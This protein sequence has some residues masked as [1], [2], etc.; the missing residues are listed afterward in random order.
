MLHLGVF[1]HAFRAEHLPVIFAVELDLLLGMDL[2]VT[3][4]RK[5]CDLFGSVL[6]V[7][8]LIGDAHLKSRQHLVV[9]RQALGRLVMLELV[10]RALDDLVLVQHEDALIAE[11]VSARERDGLFVVVVIRLKADAALENAIYFLDNRLVGFHG[12]RL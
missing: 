2:A 10:V 7:L 1:E 6:L 8:A 9:D 5:H 4:G 3:D 11:R 12:L